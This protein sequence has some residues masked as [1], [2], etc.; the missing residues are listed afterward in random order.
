MTLQISR[1]L[2]VK[3]ATFLPLLLFLFARLQ[4]AIIAHSRFGIASATTEISFR[5]MQVCFGDDIIAL[6]AKRLNN[7]IPIV[8]PVNVAISHCFVCC[9]L[10]AMN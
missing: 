9:L 7:V 2:I 5:Q 6:F 1:K 8:R 4:L 10:S 3:T